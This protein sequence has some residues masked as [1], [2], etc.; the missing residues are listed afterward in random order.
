MAGS[1]KFLVWVMVLFV[2]ALF[3][4]ILVPATLIQDSVNREERYLTEYFGDAASKRIKGKAKRTYRENFVNTGAVDELYDFFL[5]TDEAL[6]GSKGLE[7]LGVNEGLW[8]T[9]RDRLNAFWLMVYFFFLR[10]YTI[11]IW[12]PLMLIFISAAAYDGFVIRK[13]KLLGFESTAAPVFG[14]AMHVFVF[15]MFM[16]FF[17]A[18][19]PVAINPLA[20]PLWGIATAFVIKTKAANLQRF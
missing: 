6:A 11:M 16:P 20:V 12:W 18:L 17:Y 4:L 15:L 13:I 10:M 3:I 8:D 7:K 19:S 1:S 9:V 5:P 2:Q 14:L